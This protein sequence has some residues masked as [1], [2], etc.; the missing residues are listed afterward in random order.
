MMVGLLSQRNMQTAV[1]LRSSTP[2][3]RSPMTQDYI[4]VRKLPCG[5]NPGNGCLNI[6]QWIPTIRMDSVVPGS[7]NLIRV[8]LPI[9]VCGE[10]KRLWECR[11]FDVASKVM[12]AITHQFKEHY[13]EPVP[14]L[15]HAILEWSDEGEFKF[16]IPLGG[17]MWRNN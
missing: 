4:R 15:D 3:R 10:C 1:V 9:A 16:L 14:P 7:P 12:P 13:N 6:G 17:A 11:V 2:M 5:S 8:P